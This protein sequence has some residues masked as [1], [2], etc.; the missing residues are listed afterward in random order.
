MPQKPAPE[1][2]EDWREGGRGMKIKFRKERELDRDRQTD[3]QTHTYTDRETERQQ[4]DRQ[5]NRQMYEH[6]E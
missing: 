3:R 6:L 2:E 1:R 5:T 4:A